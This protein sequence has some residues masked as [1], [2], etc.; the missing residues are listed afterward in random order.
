MEMP[1]ALVLLLSRHKSLKTL[2][3][4]RLTAPEEEFCLQMASGL[5][6]KYPLFPGSPAYL[7]TSQI[8]D[9]LASIMIS[10]NFLK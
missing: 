8:L 3:G 1:R 7:P 4:K 5:T 10:V 6:L 2:R 9:L